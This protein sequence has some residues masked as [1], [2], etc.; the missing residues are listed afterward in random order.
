MKLHPYY[1]NS[2]IE[3]YLIQFANIFTGFQVKIGTGD[4]ER[5]ISVPV[6]YGSQD[7]VVAAIAADSTTNK[8]L[9]LPVMSVNMSKLDLASEL[10]RGVGQEDRFTYL[11]SGEMFPEGLKTLHRYMPIPYVISA[12]L[13]ILCS[14]QMQQL[15]LLEQLLVLFDPSL[16][17]QTSD[18]RF[19]WTKLTTV[20]LSS[21]SLDE[22]VPSAAEER[23]IQSHLVFGFPIYLTPPAKKTSEFVETIKIRM[24]D[25]DNFLGGVPSHD[26]FDSAVSIGH[27]NLGDVT[28]DGTDC[29][30]C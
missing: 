13:F 28:V 30:S 5:M 14:N 21:I 4:K 23:L 22:T 12:D 26:W 18:A 16:V 15:Q 25:L 11:P 3:R 8:P 2:Q 29:D 24:H 19:D 6:M 9:R 17:I 10:Y 7:K 20:T 27:P 1:Y